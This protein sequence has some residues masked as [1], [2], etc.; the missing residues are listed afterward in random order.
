MA[1]FLHM[2]GYAAYVW[3]SFAVV[4]GLMGGLLVKSWHDGRRTAA[5]LALLQGER[6][7]RRQAP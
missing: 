6:R 3:P 1:E 7:A 4:L 2:G 5:A